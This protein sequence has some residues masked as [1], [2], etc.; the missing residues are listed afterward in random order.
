M[1]KVFTL[2]FLSLILAKIKTRLLKLIE[3]QRWR[4]HLQQ[5]NSDMNLLILGD[6]S[7]SVLERRLFKGAFSGFVARE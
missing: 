6:F 1:S 4:L 5:I 2:I 3:K 7:L